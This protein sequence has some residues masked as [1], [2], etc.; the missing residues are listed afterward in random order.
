MGFAGSVRPLESFIEWP[1]GGV[2]QA[3]LIFLYVW[4]A[5]MPAQQEK[6]SFEAS[7]KAQSHDF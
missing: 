2:W 1:V 4:V 6:Y 3:E 7:S 5:G